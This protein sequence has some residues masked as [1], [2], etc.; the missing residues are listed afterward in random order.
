MYKSTKTL[1]VALEPGEYEIAFV[2]KGAYD[3]L[4]Q[5]ANLKNLLG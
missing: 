2:Y 5:N 1:F 3:P 4:N